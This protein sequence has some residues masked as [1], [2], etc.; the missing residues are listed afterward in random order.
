MRFV[1]ALIV[2]AVLSVSM[3]A[4]SKEFDQYLRACDSKKTEPARRVTTCTNLLDHAANRKLSL[5][6]RSR[7]GR[8]HVTRWAITR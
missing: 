6:N 5:D 3:L 2:C 1:L 8:S 7:A 4:Q